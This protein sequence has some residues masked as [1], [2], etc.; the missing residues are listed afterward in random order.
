MIADRIHGGGSLVGRPEDLAPEACSGGDRA[1]V[2]P[3]RQGNSIDFDEATMVK[4]GNR[5][6]GPGWPRMRQKSGICRVEPWPVLYAHDVCRHAQEM[7]G[8]GSSCREDLCQVRDD[9][10]SLFLEACMR[11]RLAA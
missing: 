3:A 1:S 7:A 4:L 6:H 10:P 9:Q 11:L 2:L 5:H 8:I